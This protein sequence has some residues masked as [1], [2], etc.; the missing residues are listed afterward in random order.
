MKKKTTNKKPVAKGVN[1]IRNDEEWT[2]ERRRKLKQAL[3]APGMEDRKI[4]VDVQKR[5]IRYTFAWLLILEEMYVLKPDYWTN[6]KTLVTDPDYIFKIKTEKVIAYNRVFGK[7]LYGLVVEEYKENNEIWWTIQMPI[8]PT[9][10]Y[11]K[12][13]ITKDYKDTKKG[14]IKKTT[15]QFEIIYERPN[16]KNDKKLMKKLGVVVTKR[17]KKKTK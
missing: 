2:D 9:I 1:K 5:E 4:L 17:T 8:M 3:A 7:Y 11:F 10:N 13:S 14:K 6:L 12:K 15:T 16:I